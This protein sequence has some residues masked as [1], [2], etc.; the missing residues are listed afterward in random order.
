[1][2]NG[3]TDEQAIQYAQQEAFTAA[4]AEK[5]EQQKKEAAAQKSAAINSKTQPV[6]RPVVGPSQTPPQQE[7]QSQANAMTVQANVA[8]ESLQE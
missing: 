4:Q 5:E 8:D 3:Y 7:G 6:K 2:D 1:M